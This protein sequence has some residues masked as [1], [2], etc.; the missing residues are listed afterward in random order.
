MRCYRT[1]TAGGAVL[2]AVLLA[3]SAYAHE[4]IALNGVW[5][6]AP[7]KSDFAGDR[8]MKSGTITIDER[9]GNIT[10]SRS[11]AYGDGENRTVFYSDST[12][13]QHGATVHRG[14]DL[15]SKIRWDDDVLTVITTARSGAVTTETYRLGPDGTMLVN[16]VRPGRRPFTLVFARQ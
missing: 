16:V 11:F 4:H 12:D 1:V 13:S 9:E 6:L 14:D 8:V 3:L 5:V 2:A 10:V 15:K 7:E